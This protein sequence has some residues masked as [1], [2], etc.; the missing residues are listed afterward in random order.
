MSINLEL[1]NFFCLIAEYNSFSEA[2]KKL[3]ISQPA[4]TQKIHDLETGLGK[5]LFIRTSSGIELTE[6]GKLLYKKVKGPINIL[7]D[8]ENNKVQE[9]RKDQIE[10][11]IDSQI[12][13][14]SFLYRMLIKFY[15]LYP[16]KRLSIKKIEI[17]KGM[18]YIANEKIDFYLASNIKKLRRKNIN[19]ENHIVLHPCFYAST[20]FYN[21]NKQS[22]NLFSRNKYTYILCKENSA[23]REILNKI[24]K[25]YKINIEQSYEAENAEMQYIL[26]KNNI[27]ISFGFKENIIEEIESGQLKEIKINKEIPEYVID[28]VEKS[29]YKKDFN[30]EQFLNKIKENII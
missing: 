5:K 4:I 8:I 13:D 23:E 10:I 20:E 22:L 21:K 16:Q 2:S 7:K 1:Y 17:E 19:T 24:V 6:E 27:G 14:I 30:K 25:K 26:V 12:F 9:D 29:E 28:I 3:Y 11:G 15:K 18:D